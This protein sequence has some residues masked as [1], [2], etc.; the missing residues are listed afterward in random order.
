M[1]LRRGFK[2]EA[3]R[4]ARDIRREMKLAAHAPLCPTALAEHLSIP[5][6]TLD[7][8]LPEAPDAVAY[9]RSPKG[10]FEFSAVTIFNG[11]RRVIV[12]NDSHSEK[13]QVSN[14]IH[15]LSHG[16]LSHPPKPPF[17]ASGNRHYDKT[18]EDEANWLGPALLI[19]PEAAMHIAEQGYS[20]S[21]AS[22]LFN[23]TEDVVRMRINVCG[24]HKRLTSR[25][26]AR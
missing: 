23:V 14:L 16:L 1:N 9:L 21:A 11:Y 2:A 24:I 13:R 15:E 12:H 5:V 19:S 17:D 20:V 8:L 7:W 4:L 10:R 6:Y 25:S 22:N 18:L 3:D 26:R